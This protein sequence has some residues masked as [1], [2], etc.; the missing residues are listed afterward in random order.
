MTLQEALQDKNIN[1]VTRPE[2][3]DSSCLELPPWI[4]EHN[5]RGV[6]FHLIDNG[7][8]IPIAIIQLTTDTRDDWQ[9]SESKPWSEK[10]NQWEL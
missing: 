4:Q 10:V 5:C 2:W 7:K 3:N 9:L 6:W 8:K 1:Y